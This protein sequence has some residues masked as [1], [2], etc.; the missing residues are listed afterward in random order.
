LDECRS[1]LFEHAAFCSIEILAFS[2]RPR[3]FDFL[4]EAPGKIKLSKKEILARV[5]HHFN[6]SYLQSIREELKSDGPAVLARVS[7]NF[8]SV[9]YFIKRFKQVVART[10]HRKHLTGGTLWESRFDS[11]YVEP[12]NASQT[13]AAWVDHGC[14]RDPSGGSPELDPHC[15]IGWAASGNKAARGMIRRMFQDTNTPTNWPGT[16]KA[17][18]GFCSGEPEQAKTRASNITRKPPLT[19]HELLHHPVTHFHSG[20]A[21][22][23]H[24]F[25][26]KLFDLNHEIFTDGREKGPRFITGQNDPSLFTLRDKGDLRKPRKTIARNLL[27]AGDS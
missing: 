24:D 7:A 18:R 3:S 12:G 10:Y 27:F 25:I 6:P 14:A 26:Q 20:M 13:I 4:V 9:S 19:R 17:W 16:L 11:C 8:G 22:G 23:S 1:L 15:T 2:L 21:I 5:E